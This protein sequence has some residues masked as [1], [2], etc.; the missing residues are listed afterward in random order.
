MRSVEEAISEVSRELQVRRR[1]YARWVLDGKLSNIDARDRLE[2]L[3]AAETYLTAFGKQEE[4]RSSLTDE[5]ISAQK[6]LD[7]AMHG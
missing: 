6:K 7:G 2:R 1:C 4:I 5:E 3:E